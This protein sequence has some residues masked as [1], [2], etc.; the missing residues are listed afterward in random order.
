MVANKEVILNVIEM[1]N[2]CIDGYLKAIEYFINFKALDIAEI[3]LEDILVDN[4]L[5][6]Y[7]CIENLIKEED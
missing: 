6:F 4:F 2:E 5:Q 7:A 1:M 3:F